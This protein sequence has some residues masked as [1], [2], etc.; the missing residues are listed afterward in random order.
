M[1][2]FVLFNDF[3]E[4]SYLFETRNRYNWFFLFFID[5]FCL[6]YFIFRILTPKKV[7][8]EIRLLSPWYIDCLL[9]TIYSNLLEGCK[10]SIYTLAYSI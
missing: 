8:H 10:P 5:V 7:E 6:R 3:F 9:T 2:H 1:E 4:F